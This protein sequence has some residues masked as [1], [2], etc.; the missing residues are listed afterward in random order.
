VQTVL[1]NKIFGVMVEPKD[2][3]DEALLELFILDDQFPEA[4]RREIEAH[5]ER[6][7]ACRHKLAEL[8]MFYDILKEEMDK[9]IPDEVRK[10]LERIEK[11]K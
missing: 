6:C 10:L 9:P 11:K 8:V 7:P 2:H 3:I 1:E 4:Q 5:L